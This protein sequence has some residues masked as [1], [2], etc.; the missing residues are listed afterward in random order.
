MQL[1]VRGLACALVPSSYGCAYS[2]LPRPLSLLLRP[3]TPHPTKALR[4]I[5]IFGSC[6]AST[7][8]PSERSLRYI[9]LAR[10]SE[11]GKK[12]GSMQISMRNILR[13][14]LSF[15]SY[16]YLY[17]K[18]SHISDCEIHRYNRAFPFSD[19]RIERSRLRSYSIGTRQ[20]VSTRFRVSG[21]LLSDYRGEKDA[22]A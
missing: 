9:S 20:G 10:Y 22:S 15:V 13:H 14:S 11:H 1:V 17:C 3:C 6:A 7:R 2:R 19:R 21:R 18:I 4:N 12:N 5:S 8:Q 16:R